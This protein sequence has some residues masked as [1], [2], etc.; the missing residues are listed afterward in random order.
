MGAEEEGPRYLGN[1]AGLWITYKGYSTTS[2]HV[3]LWA[4][5]IEAL[6]H[7]HDT[8]DRAL[9]VR[10]DEDLEDAHWRREQELAGD[11]E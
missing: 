10:W 3:R 11:E 8:G 9:F 6:R 4:S 7:A 5:E 2:G 1:V